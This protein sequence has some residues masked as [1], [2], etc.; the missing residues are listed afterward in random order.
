M[1]KNVLEISFKVIKL[2]TKKLKGKRNV[3]KPNSYL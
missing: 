3:M 2:N 1:C